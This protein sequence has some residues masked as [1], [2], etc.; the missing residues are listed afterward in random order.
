M[1]DIGQ[2]EALIRRLETKLEELPQKILSD[3]KKLMDLHTHEMGGKPIWKFPP[4]VVKAAVEKAAAKKSPQNKEEQFSETVS[5]KDQCIAILT[6][7][8]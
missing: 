2:L 1:S 8:E 3:V 5:V 6:P 4:D 7:A